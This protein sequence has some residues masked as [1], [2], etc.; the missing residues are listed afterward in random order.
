MIAYTDRK[1]AF[2][3]LFDGTH[4]ELE[5]QGNK[6]VNFRLNDNTRCKVLALAAVGQLTVART[7]RELLNYAV[8]D[9]MT[10]LDEETR[11]QV[12]DEFIKI[13]TQESEGK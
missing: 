11:K 9:L 1:M 2:V 13:L 3:S 5:E 7:Y 12:N 8:D 6:H 4:R 10:E